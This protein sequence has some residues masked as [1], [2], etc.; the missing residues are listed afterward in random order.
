MARS[1]QQSAE[2]E[3]QRLAAAAEQE[4]QRLASEQEK[5]RLA[6]EQE[7]QRLSAEQEKQRLAAAAAIQ[8]EQKLADAAE[9]EKQTYTVTASHPSDIARVVPASNLLF[10][11][12]ALSFSDDTLVNVLLSDSEPVSSGL[13]FLTDEN[14]SSSG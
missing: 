2:Q 7:K 8:E 1:A 6:A 14:S 4:R 3:K 5:Q 11:S 9:Q 12:R 10:G 13:L